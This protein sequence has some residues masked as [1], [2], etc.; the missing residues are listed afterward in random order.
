MNTE[1][2]RAALVDEKAN[3]EAELATIGRRNPEN[4]NDWEALPQETG[5][6]SDPNDAAD[7][8]SHYEDNTAILKDLEIRYNEVLAA[9]ARIDEGTYGVCTVSGEMI[10][11]DRLAA[12]AAATTCKAH[13]NT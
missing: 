8:I 6:E 5:Q 7:L 2:Y 10:E 3:L 11:E 13:L 9:L 1:P 12:D 4:P